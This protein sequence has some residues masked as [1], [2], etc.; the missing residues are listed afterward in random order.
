MNLNFVAFSDLFLQRQEY[1]WI[2][3]QERESVSFTMLHS[4]ADKPNIKWF[5]NYMLYCR[6]RLFEAK[7]CFATRI[8][9]RIWKMC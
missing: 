2:F 8:I 7:R 3:N 4:L 9:Q 5:R 6:S 1:F